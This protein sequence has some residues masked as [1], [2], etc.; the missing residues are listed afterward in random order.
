VNRLREHFGKN[1]VAIGDFSKALIRSQARLL[2]IGNLLRCHRVVEILRSVIRVIDVL[3]QRRDSAQ[4]SPLQTA[5]NSLFKL[6]GFRTL[7]NLL[8]QQCPI[9]GM[10]HIIE[11]GQKGS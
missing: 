10:E 4:I 7:V 3:S 9:T 5:H 6:F 8:S 1:L 11:V 2:E